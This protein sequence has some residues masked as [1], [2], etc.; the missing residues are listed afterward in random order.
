MAFRTGRTREFPK[1]APDKARK[2]EEKTVFILRK[3]GKIA[4]VQNVEK[5]LL[6]GLYGY[7]S[8]TGK[9][10]ETETENYFRNQYGAKLIRLEKLP[11][12]K[13]IFSHVEW[14]MDAYLIETADDLPFTF[15]TEKT[16]REKIPMATAYKKWKI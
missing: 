16:L 6:S 13:H 7:P 15:V 9:L 12:K 11:S 5:G 3:D 1:K 4:V 10:D 8:V 14:H 2:I